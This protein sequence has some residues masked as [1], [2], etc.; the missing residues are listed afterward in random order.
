MNSQLILVNQGQPRQLKA[1]NLQLK[2]TNL[3]LIATN[4]AGQLKTANLQL[5]YIIY[6]STLD[7]LVQ[8]CVFLSLSTLPGSQ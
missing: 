2:A 3:Q 5:I 7:M 4:C 6:Q 8:V 1:T